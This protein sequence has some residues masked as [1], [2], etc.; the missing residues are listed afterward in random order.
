MLKRHNRIPV[1]RPESH[2]APPGTLKAPGGAA[3]SRLSVLAYSPDGFVEE[4]DIPL[5][6]IQ[7][8]RGQNGVLWVNLVGLADVEL[9][10]ELGDYFGLHRLA[11]EDTLNI[12][13]RP[14]FEDYSDHQYL[15]VRMPVSGKAL[16]TE[17]VSVFLGEGYVLTVQERPGDCFEGIR[18]RIRQGRIR[19]RG[20]GGDYLAY[21]IMDAIVDS[22][23]PLLEIVG[24]RLDELEL[25][26]LQRP[27]QDQITG[28]YDLKRGLVSLRRYLVPLRELMTVMVREDLVY[29][30]DQTRVYLRDCYDHS[31]Q[32]VDLVESYRDVASGLMDLYLSLISQRMNEVMKVLTIIATLF[33]PLS[34]IAGLYGMNFDPAV[35]RWNMPE[36]AWPFG[37][38][39][40]WGLMLSVAGGMLV[41][42]WRKGWFR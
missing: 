35:S 23:F 36:L 39:F 15:V 13:Q 8:L 24:S 41:Y 3:P 31:R 1:H 17:Q 29:F 27:E 34:F 33:I 30:S 20:S 28:L 5:A 40:A 25:K 14:K 37:Y 16:E 11:L 21:T 9:V 22:F 32:A 10:Q 26:I 7:E 6:R 38:I 18:N 19:I 12:P 2:G 42:F 4:T